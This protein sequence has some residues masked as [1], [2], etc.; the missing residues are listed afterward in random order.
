VLLSYPRRILR[1][2]LSTAGEIQE[3]RKVMPSSDF[4]DTHFR[5]VDLGAFCDGS[6]GGGRRVNGVNGFAGRIPSM[7]GNKVSRTL[8][9]CMS[10]L[11]GA[12]RGGV[13]DPV[14]PTCFEAERVRPII[15]KRYGAAVVI[16]F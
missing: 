7:F 9:Q 2:V 15:P 10:L 12:G 3:M 16:G 4:G 6:R 11:G 1:A 5:S 14:R 8:T 13:P